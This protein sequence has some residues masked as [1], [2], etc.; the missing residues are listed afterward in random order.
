MEKHISRNIVAKS[1]LRIT[2]REF[3][4]CPS[5]QITTITDISQPYIVSAETVC[6]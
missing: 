4:L 6:T 2:F 1:L 3:G 5:A